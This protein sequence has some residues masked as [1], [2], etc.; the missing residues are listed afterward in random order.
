MLPSHAPEPR[1]RGWQEGSTAH[2]RRIGIAPGVAAART[3]RM[4]LRETLDSVRAATA[5]VPGLPDVVAATLAE[6]VRLDVVAAALRPGDAFPDFLLPDV[7]GGL[8]GRDDL[9]RRGPAVVTFF[10]GDWCP[11]CS[12]TLDALQ[13]ALPEIEAAGGVLAAITPETGGRARQAGLRHAAGYR[14][15]VDVDHGL[16]AACGVAFRVPGRYRDM[17]LAAGLDLAER[18][19]N[20]AWL[21]PV[22]AAFVLRP[23]G[24]VAWS[25]VDPDFT[26]R[27][28]PA[29]LVAALREAAAG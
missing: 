21:L 22:P 10:R 8:V 13:A 11:Y 27:A 12:A 24:E 18:Q 1:G 6:L 19:G 16:A 29:E 4:T 3:G 25:F 2:A 9:L 7:A 20:A 15:L 14:V 26:R 23:S 5:A 17:L 28:E